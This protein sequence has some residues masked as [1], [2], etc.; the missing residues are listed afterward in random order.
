MHNTSIASDGSRDHRTISEAIREAPSL[1]GSPYVIYITRG[2]Y[3]ENVVIPKDKKNLV[4]IG[5]GMEVT[6]IIGHRSNASGFG[7]QDTATLVVLGDGFM[8]RDIGIVNAAGPN[9]NQAV[10]LRTEAKQCVFYRCRIEGYQDSLYAKRYTQFYRECE[11]LGTVDFIFG[12]STTVLQN[13]KI[14]CRRPNPKQHVT[15]TADGKDDPGILTG[16]VLHNCS[17]LATKELR[18][19][20]PNVS[21]YLGRPWR[22]YSTTVVMQSFI[23][24]FV[25]PQGWSPWNEGENETL[26]TL[27]YIEYGNRGPGSNTTSRVKWGG[28]KVFNNSKD[29]LQFTVQN[30]LNGSDWLPSTGVPFLPGL[31]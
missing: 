8:A 31:M 4:F 7:T 6:K 17:I 29:V 5:D 21:S 13:C 30:F 2:N 12:A 25:S 15:V 16:I 18:E 10:A 23:G 19:A 28:F 24:G 26:S 22:P 9:G 20:K 3:Y 27:T 14:Y 11:I 1:S